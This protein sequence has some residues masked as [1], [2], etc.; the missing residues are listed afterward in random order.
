MRT[1]EEIANPKVVSPVKYIPSNKWLILG[2]IV[3]IILAII[4]T[5]AF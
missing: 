4:E 1:L 2:A 5:M 3:A